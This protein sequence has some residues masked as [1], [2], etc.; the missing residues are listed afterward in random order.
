MTEGERLSKK[1]PVVLPEKYGNFEQF[2]KYED[3]KSD[4]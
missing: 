1:E 4:N 3:V 2:N